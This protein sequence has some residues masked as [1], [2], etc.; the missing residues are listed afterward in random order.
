MFT[1][2]FPVAGEGSRFG[3]TFKPL[4]PIGDITFIEKVYEPFQKYE[5]P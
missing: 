3:G 2:I 4:L 5:G 1:L